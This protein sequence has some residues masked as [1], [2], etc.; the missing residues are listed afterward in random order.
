MLFHTALVLFLLV[1]G[2]SCQPGQNTPSY[3]LSINCMYCRAPN[4]QTAS[5]AVLMHKCVLCDA[6]CDYLVESSLQQCKESSRAEGSHERV[7]LGHATD[8]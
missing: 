1:A 5:S 2:T 8:Q 7:S 6:L 3:M 4:A